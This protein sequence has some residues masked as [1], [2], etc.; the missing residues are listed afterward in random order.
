MKNFEYVANAGILTALASS[1]CCITPLLAIIAGSSGI[2]ATFDWIQPARPY[3]IGVTVL[4]LGFSWYQHL[5]PVST[6]SCDCQPQNKPFMQTKIFLTLITAA[7]VL[8]VAFPSY[9]ELIY[10]EKP[11]V[12]QPIFKADQTAFIKIKGMTCEGCEHHV[13]QEVQKLKGIENVQVS[14]KNGNATVKYDSKKTSLAE[15]KKAVD[16]T[17]YKIIEGN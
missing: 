7:S 15:I 14:Y 13:K 4:T 17:G 2:A 5:R 11:L 3:L 9:A 6:S 12:Q 1:V 10:Q 16:A 8:L